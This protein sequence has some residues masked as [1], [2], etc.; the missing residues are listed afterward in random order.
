MPAE[1]PV[2]TAALGCPLSAPRSA[3]GVVVEIS[4]ASRTVEFKNHV[5]CHL[6]NSFEKINPV[7]DRLCGAEPEK[8]STVEER[9]FSAAS[10][11]K[12]KRL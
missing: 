2:G 9:R 12:T 7:E 4:E 3:F 8:S 11:S 6:E 10:T 1:P 5:S